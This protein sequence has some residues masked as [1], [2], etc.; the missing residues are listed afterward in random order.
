MIIIADSGG[1]KTDWRII[2]NEGVISQHQ[3]LG[4]NPFLA[5]AEALRIE[6]RKVR[7]TVTAGS[8][9]SIFF[10][11]AGCSNPENAELIRKILSENFSTGNVEVHTDLLGA[12]RA[13]GN[14]E[15]G[16]IC[17]LGTGANSCFYDGDDIVK[18]MPSLGFILGDEGSGAYLGKL[19]INLYFTGNLPDDVKL[20]LEKRYGMNKDE[21][22]SNVY[23]GSQPAQYLA[24][25]SKFFFDNKNHPIIYELIYTSFKLFFER[26]V[27]QYEG[28]G[29]YPVHFSGSIAF[30]Y[31]TILRQAGKD[32]GIQVRNIVENPI[33]GLTLFHHA[34][35][36]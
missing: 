14:K 18:K 19:I 7:D 22:L 11:G 33:A 2:S 28:A 24:R 27:L 26:N 3:T 4:M 30:Y 20:K 21:I 31:N 10:Y 36:L 12:A 1:T 29:R 15:P 6:V 34:E 23:K 32:L 5:D 17:I 8:D 25:F 35:K 9:V 16:I 13:L